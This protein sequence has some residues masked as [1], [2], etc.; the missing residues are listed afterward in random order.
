HDGVLALLR[1]ADALLVHGVGGG[2][3]HLEGDVA[4]DL[5]EDQLPDVLRVLVLLRDQAGVRG[6]PGQHAP[7]VDL[8]DLFDAS[9]VEE[10]PHD[11]LPSCTDA[12]TPR[13]CVARSVVRSMTR[14][15]TEASAW[16]KL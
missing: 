16:S 14:S 12:G 7:A 5:L 4:L 1:Q 2:L 6:D 11:V 8:A 10:Q 15:I 9:G 3:R 13:S